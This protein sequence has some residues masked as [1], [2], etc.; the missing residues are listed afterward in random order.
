MTF[1][2][3]G[4]KKNSATGQQPRRWRKRNNASGKDLIDKPSNA[5]TACAIEETHETSLESDPDE[6]AG[7]HLELAESLM[8]FVADDNRDSSAQAATDPDGSTRFQIVDAYPPV[9]CSELHETNVEIDPSKWFEYYGADFSEEPT[10]ERYKTPFGFDESSSQCSEECSPDLTCAGTPEVTSDDKNAI[11]YAS[12]AS[13][14]DEMGNEVIDSDPEQAMEAARDNRRKHPR[15]DSSDLVWVEYFNSSM[16]CTGK[17][18]ARV[19]NFGG[20]GM[21]IAVKTAPSE[22]ERVIV[23]YPCR[24]F[25][26]CSL[27]RSRYQGEDGQEHLCLEFVDREWKVNA[28]GAPVEITGDYVNPRKILLADDDAAFRKILG[29]I[30]I[31]T[32]YDVVL[33]EDGEI[34]VEKATRENPDLVIT[35]G[36]MPKLH[37][38]QVC[39]A[40]KELNPQPK[41]ILLTAVYTTPNYLWEAKTKFGADDILTKPCQIADLLRKIEK[42]MPTSRY[43][44]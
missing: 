42:H 31:K 7:E 3:H 25:E 15:E 4:R 43:V 37:G 20:G 22:L 6:I 17:E 1:K 35:D 28:T 2:S 26:S 40:V 21:R 9:P 44:V 12:T 38:F 19:E 13:N 14:A 39:K 32:G 10:E 41:V 29:N 24:G 11:D 33:A 16:E 23:S 27:M 30:L 34:A 8:Q 5:A 18:A 36:L